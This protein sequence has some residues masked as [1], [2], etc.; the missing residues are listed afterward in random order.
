MPQPT[1]TCSPGRFLHDNDLTGTIPTTIE[2]LTA[3]TILYALDTSIRVETQ[4]C[5][6]KENCMATT[7]W[8]KRRDSV[9]FSQ[10]GEEANSQYYIQIQSFAD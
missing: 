2:V 4:S 7:W 9:K 10:I 6:P 5:S 8:D 3:L 1:P